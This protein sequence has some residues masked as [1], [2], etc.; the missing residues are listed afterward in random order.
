[1]ACCVTHTGV[2]QDGISR[3]LA[4]SRFSEFL[5]QSVEDVI[6]EGFDELLASIFFV[7][8]ELVPLVVLGVSSDKGALGL[9]LNRVPEAVLAVDFGALL[10]LL[11]LAI[12]VDDSLA[13]ST[14]HLTAA[15]QNTP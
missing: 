7:E 8:Q 11:S 2:N 13:S 3:A 12:V 14:T 4:F 6:R 5:F 9:F 15:S 1:M 10:H